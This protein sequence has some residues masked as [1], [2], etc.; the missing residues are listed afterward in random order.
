MLFRCGGRHVDPM[1]T[2]FGSRVRE[3]RAQLGIT[4]R[5][6]AREAGVHFASIGKIETGSR[7]TA[8]GA[9]LVAKLATALRVDAN[10][11]L[12]GEQTGP[13]GMQRDP[14]IDAIVAE[15]EAQHRARLYVE[16]VSPTDMHAL[17]PLRLQR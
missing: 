15:L 10:W 5:E 4:Q 13:Q 2:G 14:R 3:T 1:A 17:V 7:D 8:P 9:E 6:L 16:M 12:T 11:L